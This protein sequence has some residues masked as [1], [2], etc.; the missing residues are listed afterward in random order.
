MKTLLLIVAATAVSDGTPTENHL[1]VSAERLAANE[2]KVGTVLHKY[3][4]CQKRF[5]KGYRWDKE[6]KKC[7]VRELRSID[8]A[9][10][11]KSRVK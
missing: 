1:G 11:I 3:R 4:W 7:R 2:A 8:T 6:A 5:D 9:P 10:E